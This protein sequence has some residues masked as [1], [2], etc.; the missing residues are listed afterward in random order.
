MRRAEDADEVPRQ[1]LERVGLLEPLV[2]HGLW[3]E[4]DL[5]R[6]D[7]PEP[8][9]VDGLQETIAATPPTP[10]SRHAAVAA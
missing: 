4:A 8:E 6:D 5:C 7:E 9:A 3:D 2:A 1:A 10:P